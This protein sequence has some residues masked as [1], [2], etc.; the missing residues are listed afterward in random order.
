MAG[1]IENMCVKGKL[2]VPTLYKDK[3]ECCGCGA[4]MA[5]CPRN[6]ISMTMDVEG[7]LYPRIDKEQCIGCLQCL[8]VCAFKRKD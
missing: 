5:V 1:M 7:F 4:C 6:A 3:G 2:I 8:Q